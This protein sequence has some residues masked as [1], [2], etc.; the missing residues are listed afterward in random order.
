MPLSLP[1][2]ARVLKRS[3]LAAAALAGTAA[4][5]VASSVAAP[6]VLAAAPDSSAQHAYVVKITNKGA[7]PDS[8]ATILGTIDA[9]LQ[10]WV[11]ESNGALTS[12]TRVGTG[13]T[14]LKTATDCQSQS[15]LWD[16]AE[17]LFPDVD[18]GGSSGNH[19]IV[20]GPSACTG[21]HGTIGSDGMT[22]GGEVT[23]SYDPAKSPQTLLH[24]LG[25]NF[26][27]MH[28]HSLMC[29]PTCTDVEYGDRYAIMGVT[30]SST[31]AYV[32]ASLD[33]YE[34]QL[35]G[36][37]DSCEI[38]DASLPTEV[39]SASRTYTLS[40]RGTDSGERGLRITDPITGAVYYLDF[41][42][43]AGRDSGAYYVGTSTSSSAGWFRD[44]V[45]V[46]QVVHDSDGRAVSQL[47]SFPDAKNVPIYARVAG[48]SFDQGGVHVAVN[49]V[50]APGDPSA[51]AS[52]TVTLSRAPGVTAAADQLADAC[53]NEAVAPPPAPTLS[54]TDAAPT[55]SPTQTPTGE[56]TPTL[57]PTP[58]TA[59]TPEPTASLPTPDLPTSVPTPLP[60][61]VPT[62][63]PTALPTDL[64]TLVPT[65]LP[66]A[67][68]TALPTALPSALPTALPT[69]LP[70]DLPTT[71]PTD[72]ATG[73]SATSAP[74]GP[75]TAPGPSATTPPA[76]SPSVT[77]APPPTTG[78]PTTAPPTTGGPTH[79]PPD[80]TSHHQPRP[81]RHGL[82]PSTGSPRLLLAEIAAAAFALTF[83]L[84]LVL[85]GRRPT[86]R[87]AGRVR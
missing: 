85:A 53:E 54:P 78:P 6:F 65:G 68:P 22:S 30:T 46:E 58:T 12:F 70:P 10:R 69:A 2:F 62:A 67:V 41:R 38:H 11:V 77:L 27:L 61:T 39:P 7:Y 82:L 33:S 84:V 34:R 83:G 59:P 14:E 81:P 15:S 49:Q 75:P 36:I 76:P 42:D 8:D 73:P 17:K 35:L 44:G 24:E 31:P 13:F 45:T 18:F 16:E 40:P 60:T 48:E 4:A 32:P 3:T 9:A 29:D 52:V 66:S 56:P 79:E 43:G 72:A 37:D 80:D 86:A 87:P 63:V 25:H 23:F 1:S 21:G 71:L 47:L 26:G 57:N 5:L 19:L 64:L 55:V 28:A 50:G 51:V 74:T 20:M